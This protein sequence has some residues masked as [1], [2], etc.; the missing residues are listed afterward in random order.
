MPAEMLVDYVRIYDN[1]FT[2]LGGSAID[3]GGGGGN[4]GTQT[5][6]AAITPGVS[7]G[8]PNKRARADVLIMDETGEP[9]ES[10]TVTVTFTGSHNGTLTS[11]TDASGNASFTTSE[12]NRTVAFEVCVDSVTH[13][14]M[15]YTPAANIETCDAY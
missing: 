6:V 13:A 2:E 3:G 15:T 9:V 5:Y 10:A 11:V 7:G 4:E 1:G 14:T 12:R 8:G